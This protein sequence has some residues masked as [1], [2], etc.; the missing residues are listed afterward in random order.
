MGV[1][2]NK[3]NRM[4]AAELED[5]EFLKGEKAAPV[6]VT[7]KKEVVPTPVHNRRMK[8]KLSNERRI[9]AVVSGRYKQGQRLPDGW[10]V[11]GYL[12]GKSNKQKE[13]PKTKTET[14]VEKV[15]RKMKVR[16]N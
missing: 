13:T 3:G 6:A 2:K 5:Q 8:A 10:K 9:N 4:S 12:M 1:K 15:L 16:N 7:V 14:Q 11:E